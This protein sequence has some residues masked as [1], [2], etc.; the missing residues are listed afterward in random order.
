MI[1]FIIVINNEGKKKLKGLLTVSCRK[2]LQYQSIIRK[3]IAAIH[4]T[5]VTVLCKRNT[6]YKAQ[7][8][9]FCNI[10][11]CTMHTEQPRLEDFK[12][13]LYAFM[14]PN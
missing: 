3:K 9:Q 6:A 1:S 8:S 10:C 2:L 7:K 11:L 14:N 4:F 5:T 13:L 12:M